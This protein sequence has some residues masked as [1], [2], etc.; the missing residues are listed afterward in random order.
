LKASVLLRRLH[1]WIA[2]VIIAPIGLVIGAGLL[3]SIKKEWAWVQ[4]PTL[5]GSAPKQIP[6][7]SAAELLAAATADPR[8]AGTAWGEFARI[9][10]QP[11]K[12]VIKFIT[13]TGWEAQVDAATAELLQVAYRRSDLIES[14][15]DGSFFSD[16]V[17]LWVF[18]PAG[19][20]LLYM[21]GSGIYLFAYPRLK[22]AS[23]QAARRRRLAE[24]QPD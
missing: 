22:A 24:L 15:H 13:K 3:L 7:R 1:Y 8:L 23:K 5:L 9:D 19:L 2:A 4:P 17:K 18:F 12:G 20:A 21:W 16:A 10:Y 11:S 6:S 14:L